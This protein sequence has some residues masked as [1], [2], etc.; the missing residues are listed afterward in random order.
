MKKGAKIASNIVYAIGVLCVLILG[1]IALFGP[2]ELPNPNAM[3]PL[4]FSALICLIVGTVPMVLACTAV[5]LFN[6]IKNKRHKVINFILIFLP[7]FICIGCFLFL[8]L[9]SLIWRFFV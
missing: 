9:G 6:D 3:V 7:G 1:S 4:S 8:M 5:Y 2:N